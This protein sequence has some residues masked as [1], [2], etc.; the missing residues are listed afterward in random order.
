MVRVKICGITQL[1]DLSTA[2]ESGAA[3]V[4]FVF[5]KNSPRNISLKEAEEIAYESPN[6]ICKVALVVNPSDVE[7]ENILN[8]VPIDMIQLH[9]QESPERVY[10]I[11]RLTKLPLMKAIGVRSIQDLKF[12]SDY[13]SV[14]DQLLIDSKPSKNSGLPG[15]NGTVFDWNILKGFKWLKPWMLAGGLNSVN[16]M[17]AIKITGAEQI[18]VSSGVE[19]NVGEKSKKKIK[20]FLETV[21]GVKNGK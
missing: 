18:D 17:S 1:E 5:H 9:G 21:N 3:Y 12:I 15:G 8:K 20:T 6:G 14:S 16:V 4:G 13:S 7:L 11:K 19:S 2:A 10:E